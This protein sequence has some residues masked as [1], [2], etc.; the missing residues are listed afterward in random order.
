MVSPSPS[1]SFSRRLG[2]LAGLVLAAG[3]GAWWVVRA[4][5]PQWTAPA[6]APAARV[7]PASATPGPPAWAALDPVPEV[8]LPAPLAPNASAAR[9]AGH[10]TFL[11]AFDAAVRPYRAGRY[12]DA[13]PALQRLTAAFPDAPEGWFYLGAARLFAGAGDAAE[14]FAR[15]TTSPAVGDDAR[16]LRAV[17]LARGGELGAAQELLTALCHG[18]GPF[19][20]RACDAL[21]QR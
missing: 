16:W 8:R 7:P 1:N 12:G 2:F 4:A 14:A 15:A 17:A 21:D 11:R 10:V 9:T 18:T 13:V 19:T 3:V 20:A 5:D 6:S